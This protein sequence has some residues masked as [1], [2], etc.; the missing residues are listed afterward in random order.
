MLQAG[1]DV[2]GKDAIKDISGS[3][4]GHRIMNVDDDD[5]SDWDN[6]QIGEDFIAITLM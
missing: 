4:T 2:K 1:S 3:I 5:E 6:L